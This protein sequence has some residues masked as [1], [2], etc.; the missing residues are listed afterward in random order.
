MGPAGEVAVRMETRKT[1]T[2]KDLTR[3]DHMGDLGR[4]GR[5]ILK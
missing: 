2:R 1:H 5:I 4:N 3:R